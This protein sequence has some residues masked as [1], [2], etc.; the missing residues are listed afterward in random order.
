VLEPYPVHRHAVE[1]GEHDMALFGWIGD[2][3]DPDNFLY[4]LFDSDNANP[5]EAQNIAFYKQPRVDELLAQAQATADQATRSQLYAEVQD[6]LATDAPWAPIAHSDLV[7]AGRA[8]VQGVVL[9]PL[10][11]PIYALMHRVVK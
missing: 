2:T 8:E 1:S 10:G 4:V 7:I 11:H 9:S 3:G 5:P 6:D